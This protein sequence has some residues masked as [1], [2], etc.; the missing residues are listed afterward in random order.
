VTVLPDLTPRGLAMSEAFLDGAWRDELGRTLIE[1]I[2]ERLGDVD[3]MALWHAACDLVEQRQMSV[4][5][6]RRLHLVEGG[7]S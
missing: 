2:C 7:G 5:R 1:A 4:T 3:G 6:D